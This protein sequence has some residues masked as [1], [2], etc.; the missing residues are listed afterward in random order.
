[1]TRKIGDKITD[2]NGLKVKIID[3]INDYDPCE[4]CFYY[5]IP[6]NADDCDQVRIDH[7]HPAE[8]IDTIGCST[9]GF[10]FVED[11]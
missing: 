8:V 1:M 11:K 5:N 6:M 7:N 3:E 4:G 10:I 9:V 2:K